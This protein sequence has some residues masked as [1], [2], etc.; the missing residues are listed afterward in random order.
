MLEATN[1]FC[2]HVTNSSL[3]K[4]HP[5]KVSRI[6]RSF[7]SFYL[8]VVIAPCH[9]GRL[10]TRIRYSEA[11]RAPIQHKSPLARRATFVTMPFTLLRVSAHTPIVEK[12]VM[13]DCQTSRIHARMGT[14]THYKSP[15]CCRAVSNGNVLRRAQKYQCHAHTLKVR[16]GPR[17]Y[18][19]GKQSAFVFIPDTLHE[20]SVPIC[21]R[22]TW[23]GAS[24]VP[25][26]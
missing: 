22:C 8:E 4:M 14:I 26:F 12:I 9:G 19:R 24:R 21:N 10:L 13:T 25:L 2:T 20:S 16:E 1:L 11:A 17:V 5:L 15:P 3:I 6:M 23:G 18:K 7:P